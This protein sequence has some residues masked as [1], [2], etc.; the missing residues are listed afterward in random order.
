[1]QT[2]GKVRVDPL[3][4]ALDAIDDFDC[5]QLPPGHPMHI[6]DDGRDLYQRAMLRVAY[7]QA[8]ELRRLR[9]A[10]VPESVMPL[11]DHTLADLAAEGELERRR[12][13]EQ[14]LQERGQ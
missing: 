8:Y 3:S 9:L 4:I 6:G 5:S 11:V 13:R 10:L 14:E 7:A 2:Q 1:M 12:R